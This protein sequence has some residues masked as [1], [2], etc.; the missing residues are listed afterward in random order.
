MSA[1]SSLQGKAFEFSVLKAVERELSGKQTIET[2]PNANLSTAETCF[3]SLSPSDQREFEAA[4]GAGVR[5]LIPREP[6]LLEQLAAG[7]LRISLQSDQKGA[8]GDVR[9][10]VMQRESD[11]WE[12]GISAK[13]NHKA[14]KS[15]RL[16]PKIDFG[17][18]WLEIP[19][20][21]S[22]RSKIKEIFEPLLPMVAKE[23]WRDLDN[24]GISKQQVYSDVLNCFRKEFL[25]IYAEH[26]GQVPARLIEYIVG[27][28]DFYKIIKLNNSTQLQPFNLHGTLGLKGARQQPIPLPAR[29]PLPSKIHSLDFAEA[30]TTLL[31]VCDA[32]WQISFR[33]H[34]ASTL[35][36]PSLK[37]DVTLVG[38][39]SSLV[40][41]ESA[42]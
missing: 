27:R 29:L 4:A 20:S 34:S 15:Q 32:G 19:C 12:I 26:G 10:L 31:M 3:N 9:D 41:Q 13:N 14:V 23:S 42:W 25:D 35:V 1:K 17:K 37:F 40:S 16:G 21:L 18:S 11:G 7:A 28:F 5:M 24:F 36:E 33:I 38:H 2:E 22:Y 39:P 8:A 30:K 6:R